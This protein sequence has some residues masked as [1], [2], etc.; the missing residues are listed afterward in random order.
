MDNITLLT[1]QS[2]A[3]LLGWTILHSLWQITLIALVLKLLLNWTSKYDATIRY[4][5]GISGLFI[6]T[7]WSVHTFLGALEEV[8]FHENQL[9]SSAT[10]NEIAPAVI[11]ETIQLSPSVL[12]MAYPSSPIQPGN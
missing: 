12:P 8:H 3:E 11:S 1:F 4:A 9:I 7:F 2:V 5:L 6:A 10:V